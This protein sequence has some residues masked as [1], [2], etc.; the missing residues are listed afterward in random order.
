MI[1]PLSAFLIDTAIACVSTPESFITSEKSFFT[2]HNNGKIIEWKFNSKNINNILIGE[3]NIGNSNINISID[4]LIVKRRYIAHTEKVSG[5]YYSDLLGL[6]ITSG[7]DNRI[8]IRK[9]YDLTLL[10]MIDLKINKFCIDIKINH[11]FLYILFY[12]EKVKKH[13]IQIYSVNGIKVGEGDYNYINGYSFDKTGNVLVG[14]YKENKIEVFNPAMTKKIDEISINYLNKKNT[15]ELNPRKRR[16][17]KKFSIDKTISEE[18]LF[19]DFIYEKDS[20]SLYCC[21]SNS[22]IIKKKY[23]YSNESS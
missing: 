9:Y 3:E 16:S 4:E 23:K 6:I 10:T 2:G 19:T 18:V 21:F 13:I 1:F 20:N 15:N 14:Y 11:C 12:D 22:Q 5:I 7:D 17:S 8:M